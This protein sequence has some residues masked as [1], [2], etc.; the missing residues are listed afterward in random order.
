[1]RYNY[2]SVYARKTFT[3]SD[4]SAV[5]GMTLRMDY[6]DGFVAYI[7]GQEVA[8]AKMPGGTPNNNTAASG[9][10]EAS[11]KG[12]F[13]TFDLA[14][15]TGNLVTGTNVLTIEIHNRAKNNNDLSMIPKLEIVNTP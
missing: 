10:H 14:L 5:T 2:I 11:K 12:G 7:N 1:M 13:E 6:D 9:N 3:V 15:Y 4:A 8:R